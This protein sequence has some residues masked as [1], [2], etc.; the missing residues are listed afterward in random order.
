MALLDACI[1]VTHIV[2]PLISPVASFPLLP[3]SLL[4]WGRCVTLIGLIHVSP[5]LT[6][7]GLTAKVSVNS[8]MYRV[9]LMNE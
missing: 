5:N 8:S 3:Q 6:I 1:Y 9:V 4:G 2:F 7:L